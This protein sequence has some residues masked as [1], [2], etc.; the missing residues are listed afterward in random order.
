M[1]TLQKNGFK[2]KMFAR[3][4]G[5]ANWLASIPNKLIPPPFRL[6]QIGSAYWQS[7][8]LHAAASL[9]LADAIGDEAIST[10]DIAGALKLH[11]DPLY[12][13]M[14]ML[15][16]IGVFEEVSHRVFRNSKI[17]NSL[18]I[19]NP[20]NVRD[21]VLMHNS[22]V[23]TRPWTEALLPG[24]RSG[25]TPF[26]QIHG[27]TLFDYMDDHPEFD[28][29]FA[30][31]MD[32]VEGLTGLDYLHDFDWSRFDRLIDVGGSKGVKALSIL[33][34][35][36]HLEAVVFDRQQVIDTAET[37]WKERGESKALERVQF[38]GGDMF[39]SIPPAR[40]ERDIYLCVAVF[41]GVSDEDAGRVLA[42]LRQA[43]GNEHPTLVVVDMVAQEHGIDPNVASFDM[44]MLV[45]THGRE[46]TRSEW[47]ALF[48]RNGFR[49]REVVDVRTFAK[50][51]VVDCT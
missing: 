32:A 47:Q 28:A 16:S 45:N 18:R 35:N 1:G 9:G 24:I 36:P 50:F 43:F 48:E 12:R 7:R 31:A 25:E 3:A 2:V 34:A 19:D 22:D 26:A 42:N 49:L 39:E 40:S 23:M 46:R 41:H 29:L 8:A 38:V 27:Q 15:S 13:L 6:I 37:F 4:M 20:Q 44:Q 5:F 30:R 21:M 51:I 14:R 33:K 11:E 10:G 17:S